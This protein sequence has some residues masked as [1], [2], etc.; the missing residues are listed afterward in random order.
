MTQSIILFKIPEFSKETFVKTK[1]WAS[2]F[3]LELSSRSKDHPKLDGCQG[4]N[5]NRNLFYKLVG[6]SA[7]NAS[8]DKVKRNRLNSD[9]YPVMLLQKEELILPD[10]LRS[11][12]SDLSGKQ[13]KKRMGIDSGIVSLMPV[14]RQKIKKQEQKLLPKNEGEELSVSDTN[15]LNSYLKYLS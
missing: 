12:N 8:E 15:L 4:E 6:L 10:T 7:S 13:S 5:P 11:I 9:D 3:I 1:G 14:K 2:P